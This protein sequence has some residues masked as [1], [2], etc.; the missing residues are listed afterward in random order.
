MNGVLQ[1]NVKHEALEIYISGC[2]GECEGC[3]NLEM[4]DYKFGN[5]LD[6]KEIAKQCFNPLVKNVWILGGEPLDRLNLEILDLLKFLHHFRLKI[7]LFTR[8]ELRDVSKNVVSHCDYIK[9]G[10][11]IKG[12]PTKTVFGITLASDNQNIH[13]IKNI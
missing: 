5:K 13:E 4:K 6:Y 9:T 1:Y 3:H 10:E 11:Y 2:M 7:W 8:Y 12:R